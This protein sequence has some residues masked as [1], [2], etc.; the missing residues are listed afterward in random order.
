[1]FSK[2][3]SAVFFWFQTWK[4]HMPCSCDKQNQKAEEIDEVHWSTDPLNRRINELTWHIMTYLFLL[5][6]N[7]R[8]KSIQNFKTLN[9][10][11]LI[12]NLI[13]WYLSVYLSMIWWFLWKAMGWDLIFL[14]PTLP[15]THTYI[16]I[17]I[18]HSS[19]HC[20]TIINYHAWSAH[21]L[22]SS[23]HGIIVRC[24]APLHDLPGDV[25]RCGPNS[26]RPRFDDQLQ[27]RK[28]PGTAGHKDTTAYIPSR[29]QRS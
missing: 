13:S 18:L 22:I 26:G 5:N 12:S 3:D 24:V 6:L 21:M 23:N 15:S 20:L 17:Y 10:W 19:H 1:M 9:S 25:R 29:C 8:A 2:N 7:F 27:C 16:Y 28:N 11:Y 14:I 4:L